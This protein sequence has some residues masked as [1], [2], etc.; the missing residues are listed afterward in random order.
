[1]GR[2]AVSFDVEKSR[3]AG[4]WVQPG[5]TIAVFQALPLPAGGVMAGK[6]TRLLFSALQVLAVDT[7]RVGQ[8]P[9]AESD[10]DKNA[11]L[12]E[13]AAGGATSHI[14]TVLANPVEA[15]ALIE[16][17]EKGPLCIV[18][19]ALGDD[20]PWALDSAVVKGSKG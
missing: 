2:V 9:A 10:S 13:A 12:A 19:R 7:V 11:L 8:A 18:L 17:R 4:G 6:S 3:A 5:D 14:V 16:A 15:T 1:M 20:I